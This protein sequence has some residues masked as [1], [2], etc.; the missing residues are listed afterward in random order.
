VSTSDV[1][2]IHFS[3]ANF[4]FYRSWLCCIWS[5]NVE[6][7]PGYILWLECLN[8]R[9]FLTIWQFSAIWTIWSESSQDFFP[10]FSASSWRFKDIVAKKS[11]EILCR[12]CLEN[13]WHY[14]YKKILADFWQNTNSDSFFQNYDSFCK[15]KKV[16]QFFDKMLTNFSKI[17]R[18]ISDTILTFFWWN[19][20]VKIMSE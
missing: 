7:S 20:V 11:T 10:V 3:I 15:K 17:F 9:L 8:F 18:Q 14:F 16:G 5:R 2:D 4:A 6:S 13:L 12:V 19:V 1:V